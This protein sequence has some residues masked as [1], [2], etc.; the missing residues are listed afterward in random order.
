MEQLLSQQD[1]SH[2]VHKKQDVSHVVHQ[3]EEQSHVVQKQAPRAELT[4]DLLMECSEEPLS[5]HQVIL[6]T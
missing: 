4:P 3:K 1:L 6:H 5:I 2:V